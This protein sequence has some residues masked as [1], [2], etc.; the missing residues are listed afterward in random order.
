MVTILVTLL[1]TL[2]GAAAKHY[3]GE[4]GWE[5]VRKA[6][7]PIARQILADPSKT[8]DPREAITEAM[9][10]ALIQQNLDRLAREAEKVERAFTVNGTNPYPKGK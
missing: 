2:I 3:V 8:D 9:G 10:A 6:A 4:K 7:K 1:G 5:A